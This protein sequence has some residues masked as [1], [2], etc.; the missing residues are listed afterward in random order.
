[1]QVV[2]ELHQKTEHAGCSRLSVAAP[3]VK[4]PSAVVATAGIVVDAAHSHAWP[5]PESVALPKK[6]LKT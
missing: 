6:M 4:I 3:K 1:M 5:P 2:E